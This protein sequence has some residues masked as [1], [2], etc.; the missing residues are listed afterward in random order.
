V[1][2]LGDESEECFVFN[3]H[4]HVHVELP[5]GAVATVA[6]DCSAETLAA[7]DRMAVLAMKAFGL[8]DEL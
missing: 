7:L 5:S 2:E 3:P 8:G 4:G 6:L 1:E